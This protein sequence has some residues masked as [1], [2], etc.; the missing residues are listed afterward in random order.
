MPGAAPRPQEDTGGVDVLHVLDR[1]GCCASALVGDALNEAFHFES[2]HRLRMGIR[3]TPKAS[4]SSE[5][6]NGAPGRYSPLMIAAR[7][8]RYA[9]STR[10]GVVG[11]RL[12]EAKGAPRDVC[13]GK[14]SQAPRRR[15]DWTAAADVIKSAIE[16]T[17]E[18][19]VE[20]RSI[21]TL[22]EALGTLAELGE[23]TQSLPAEPT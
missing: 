5:W 17:R 23:S 8:C 15:P 2:S 16:V 1:D 12:G 3:L 14:L 9:A 11:S 18:T 10:L 6:R 21:E 7:S 13:R 20:F 19:T 4:A 22:D